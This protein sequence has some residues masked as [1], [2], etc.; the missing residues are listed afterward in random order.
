MQR[1]RWFL[2]TNPLAA[3]QFVVLVGAVSAQLIRT[4]STD[5]VTADER[6]LSDDAVDQLFC[7]SDPTITDAAACVPQRNDSHE[8]AE[9]CSR[10]TVL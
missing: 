6:Y 5:A 9:P 2:P 10:F 1:V 3:A 8:A 7:L 4:A